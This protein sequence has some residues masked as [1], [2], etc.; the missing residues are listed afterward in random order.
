MHT[1]VKRS[2]F[3]GNAFVH[4]SVTGYR[5]YHFR[6]TKFSTLSAPLLA[7]HNAST[8][9]SPVRQQ[10]RHE[11]KKLLQYKDKIENTNK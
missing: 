1:L 10:R 9:V 6:T 11:Q 7:I 3:F 8:L 5:G 4:T 2:S